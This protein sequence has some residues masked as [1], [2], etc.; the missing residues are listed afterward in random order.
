MIKTTYVCDYCKKEQAH[1]THYMLPVPE[2][3]R[4]GDK[5]FCD[6]NCLLSY[7]KKQKGEKE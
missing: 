6:N 4:L 5:I 2:L 7:L 3:V 1:P